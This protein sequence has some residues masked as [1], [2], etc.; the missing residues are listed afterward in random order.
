[1]DIDMTIQDLSDLRYQAL[2]LVGA[3]PEAETRIRVLREMFDAGLEAMAVRLTAAQAEAEE[4]RALAEAEDHKARALAEEI[5]RR[6]ELLLASADRER[7]QTL[8]ITSLRT[9]LDVLRDET[10]ALR[11]AREAAEADSRVAL[12][13]MLSA[14]DDAAAA[15]SETEAAVQHMH[16]ERTRAEIATSEAASAKVEAIQAGVGM[17][18]AVDE[19]ERL[20]WD[21]ER[22]E[23]ALSAARADA[24]ERITSLTAELERARADVSAVRLDA[25]DKQERLSATL[26]EL[27]AALA[28]RELAD[29]R[30]ADML[31]QASNALSA[32]RAATEEAAAAR[33]RA[34]S[35]EGCLKA[36][37]SA[38]LTFI[39]DARGQVT[40]L[41]AHENS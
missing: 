9:D 34:A 6:E 1:M 26:A 16:E 33:A 40:T 31:W 7:L 24:N 20:R 3:R 39:G 19:A 12:E 35:A 11:G 29:I 17:R 32:M 13:G 30:G 18:A 4:A 10:A 37:T 2:S 21:V 23:E 14:N 27:T 28:A 36:V 38:R 22:L 5:E 8:R 15:R 41:S 25:M